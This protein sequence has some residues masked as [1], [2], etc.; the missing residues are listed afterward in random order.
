MTISSGTE[1]RTYEGV[2]IRSTGSW[3]EVMSGS[4][5]ISA[6]VRGK[7]RLQEQ[8]STNPVAVGDRVTLRLNEDGTG[9]IVAIHERK[10]RLSRR[11]AGRRV[12]MEHIMVA[13]VDAAW[14]VQSIRMPK[15]NPGLIDRFLVIAEYSDIPAGIIF[16]KLDLMKPQDQDAVGFLHEMYSQLGYPVLLMSALTREG[17]DVLRDA[18][19]HR[20]SVVTGPS[21]VGKSAL[22]NVVEPD[23][24]LKTNVVSEKTQK[25]RHTTTFV[26][27]YPL[28]SGGFVVDTP[29]IRE[30]GIVDMAPEDLGHC[31]VEFRPH[32]SDCHFPNCTHD[33]EPG[34]AV[35]EAVERDEIKEERHASYLNILDSLRMGEK[36]VGR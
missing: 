36:D 19:V 7:F 22:L 32:V 20:V 18:L 28:S 13:N 6:T 12:G 29:G 11:A 5:V 23:L 35:K 34:C 16:N 25:G 15:I 30:F 27:L 1:T 2:V 4:E 17:T 14:I 26:A 3:Y 33:H 9:V 24:L 31:F 21:G 8:E 10:N